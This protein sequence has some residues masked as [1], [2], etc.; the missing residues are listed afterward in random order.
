[1]T[2][3]KAKEPTLQHLSLELVP[4][5]R[6]LL[7]TLWQPRNHFVDVRLERARLVS[8]QAS[9]YNILINIFHSRKILN[10]GQKNTSWKNQLSRNN[11]NAIEFYDELGSELASSIS[12]C[13]SPQFRSGS[14]S[15]FFVFP[16]VRKG[17]SCHN[18]LSRWFAYQEAL[19]LAR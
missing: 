1:M 8:L 17:S 16:L 12:I 11:E 6:N 15:S 4:I 13:P 19:K 5:F 18:A 10:P 3:E 14:L 9:K 2:E 7:W